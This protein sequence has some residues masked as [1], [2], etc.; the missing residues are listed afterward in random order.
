MLHTAIKKKTGEL[1]TQAAHSQ[2]TNI[3]LPLC[4]NRICDELD[5]SEKSNF[6]DLDE[7]LHSLD[8]KDI[9][10][11]TVHHWLHYLGFRYSFNKKTYYP[12]IKF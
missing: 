12:D 10:P 1:S 6:P 8:L 3:I 4:Y 5:D 2:L 9:C 7:L 11:S